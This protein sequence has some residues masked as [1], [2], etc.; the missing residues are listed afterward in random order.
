MTTEEEKIRKV[1]VKDLKAGETIHTVFKAVTKE[2]HTS[3]SGK[4][5]L[6]VTLT[7]RTGAVDARVFENVDAADSA[8]AAGDYLLLKGRAGSFHGKLQVVIDR[9]ERLDPE[10]ID[11]KEFTFVAPPAPAEQPQPTQRE[12]RDHQEPGHES[13]GLSHK[14]ARQRLLRLLDNPQLTHALDLL[15][16]HL[17]SYLD[18]RIALK[19]AGGPPPKVERPERRS[20]GPRVEHKAKADAEPKHAEPKRDPTLPTGLAFKPLDQLIPE[21]PSAAPPAEPA[22]R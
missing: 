5:W 11:P 18:E 13:E 19:L 12:P 21:P 10:P 6:A 8:F 4:S 17:E 9:L 2:K 7:D 20:R 15:V 14:A 22:E 16:R 1:F 3:R